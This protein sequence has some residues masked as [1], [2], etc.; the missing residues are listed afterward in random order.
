MEYINIKN[1]NLIKFLPIEKE[2]K[3]LLIDSMEEIPED[4]QAYDWIFVFPYEE[5]EQGAPKLQK[6]F[7]MLTDQGRLYLAVENPF[8][9][10]RIAGEAEEDGSFFKAFLP[11]G[12]EK[13]KGMSLSFLTAQAKTAM[14]HCGKEYSFKVYYP[15]PDIRFPSAVYTEEYLPGPGECDENLYNFHHA[16]FGFFDEMMAVDELVKAGVY[17]QFAS[18]YLLEIAKENTNLLYCRYSVERGAG[19]KIRTSILKDGKGER[20]VQKAAFEETSNEHIRKLVSWQEKLTS[21]LKGESFLGSPLLV[22]RIL[23][24]R[25]RNGKEQVS[26]SFIKG[27]SLENYLDGYLKK[28]EFESCKETLLGFCR[29]I[30]QLKDQ[31]PFQ[32]TEEFTKVFGLGGVEL[33]KGQ[34]EAMMALPVTDIDMVCQNVL[35]GE[36]VTLIDYEWTFD[37]PIPIDYLIYRVL[38][39]YLEQKD[40]RKS[41]CF[42]NHF[43][44]YGEMGISPE[45]KKLFEQMETHFQNYAQG[46]CIL[47]RDLYLEKGRPVVPMALLKE[48]LAKAEENKVR[49]QYDKGQGFLEE[50]SFERVLRQDENGVLS[51]VLDLPKD[52]SVRGVNIS[53]GEKN[54]MIRIGLLKEDDSGSGEIAYETNGISVNPILYLYKEKP[55]LSISG[56]KPGV[57]RL[58][59]SLQIEKLPE[60]FIKEAAG[61][62]LDMREVIANREEQIANYENSTSWKLTRPLRELG[63]RK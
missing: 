25:Q 14:Q 9:L 52:M 11:K 62:I 28:G 37:F 6:L 40:R 12:F 31:Q 16:R 17:S 4:D 59:V 30:K 7:Q 13:S 47:L 50:E 38:F 29:M 44:F 10:H 5:K 55:C 36:Q 48:Q 63:R 27:E 33:G 46:D 61:S 26:F 1:D 18:G 22:N 42:D 39:C 3:L 21:Q 58:Y 53:F 2:D 34:E 19:K 57:K 51:F 32:V 56:L 8:S 49:I 41:E 15:Y 60:T 24:S 35:L 45:R 54:T 20:V 23:E 43:D